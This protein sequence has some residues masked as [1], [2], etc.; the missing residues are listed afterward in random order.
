MED[1]LVERSGNT[2]ALS[3]P[4]RA[5]K[6]SWLTTVVIFLLIAVGVAAGTFA[7]G[8]AVISNLLQSDPT[9]QR[10]KVERDRQPDLFPNA[11]EVAEAKKAKKTEEAARKAR[12]EEAADEAEPKP[13][14]D[15]D[16]VE[17]EPQLDKSPKTVAVVEPEQATKINIPILTTG[18][19]ESQLVSTLGKPNSERKGW[20]PNTKVLAYYNVVPERV[21]LSY[22]SDDTGQIRQ[23]NV[24]LAQS[25]SLDVMEQ[26]L[27]KMLGDDV[28]ADIKEKLR[29][30]YDR[31]SNF[32]FFKLNDLEGKFQRDAKDRINI[33]V[34][35]RGF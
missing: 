11:A 16:L 14:S 25:V 10:A 4:K 19:S 27:T 1:S 3:Q 26:T 15:I 7:T 30:I 21:N 35:E 2:R 18:T 12:L 23:T 6:R 33:S 17:P 22:E 31:Q 24:A 5:K 9:P 29:S 8:F 13:G 28:P 34:W 20:R 32:S